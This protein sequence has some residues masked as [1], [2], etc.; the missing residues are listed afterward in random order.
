MYYETIICHTFTFTFLLSRFCKKPPLINETQNRN[1][2]KRFA[3]GVKTLLGSFQTEFVS[4]KR[5]EKGGRAS[6]QGRNVGQRPAVTSQVSEL[7][8]TCARDVTSRPA[9]RR[10]APAVSS[11]VL[12]E[13]EGRSHISHTH[14]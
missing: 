10:T 14:G 11:A 13:S 3:K 9:D 6:C 8:D 12:T 4:S 1:S 7:R 5:K 2:G